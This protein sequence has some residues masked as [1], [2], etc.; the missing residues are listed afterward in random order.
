MRSTVTSLASLR[1]DDAGGRK[2]HPLGGEDF[3]D[4]DR[5]FVE[6]MRY[7]RH[8]EQREGGFHV[9]V[10]P[11]RPTHPLLILCDDSGPRFVDDLGEAPH[12]GLPDAPCFRIEALLVVD[13]SPPVKG[14]PAN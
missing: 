4:V 3:R 14:R 7:R 6:M 9:G 11:L 5:A 2:V 1:V 8:G 10:D 13:E 12:A